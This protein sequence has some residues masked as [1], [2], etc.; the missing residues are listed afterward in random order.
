MLIKEIHCNDG[1]YVL[2]GGDVDER[3]GIADLFYTGDERLK[4][5]FVQIEP[6]DEGIEVEEYGTEWI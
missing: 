2:A 4:V 6:E 1:F 5:S 3:E